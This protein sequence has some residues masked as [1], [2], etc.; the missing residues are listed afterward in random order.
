MYWRTPPRIKVLEALG[1]IADQRIKFVG[2]KEA[3][4]VSSTGER[5]YKVTWDGGKAIMSTDNGS[6]Y[7]GYL[8]YPSIA[9]LM[10][11]G[12][13]PFDKEIA[14]ALKGISWKKLNET[15]KKYR[16]VEEKVKAIAKE[17]GVDPAKIDSFVAKVMQEIR[18]K[19]FVKL[20]V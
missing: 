20:E 5:T 8:G 19:R 12:I 4:V 11:K 1:C 15:Y 14:D 16:I 10:L 6:L 17:R 9:F 18:A 3:V 13:L 7:R 2:E